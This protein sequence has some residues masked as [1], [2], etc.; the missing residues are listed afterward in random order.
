M[1]SLLTVAP[2]KKQGGIIFLG[3]EFKARSIFERVNRIFLVE[4]KAK[5]SFKCMYIREE[6]VDKGR[7]A[8]ALKEKSRLGV[9]TGQRFT[10]FEFSCR[11][12][13]F[14]FTGI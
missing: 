6:M 11:T 14:G 7:R 5:R 10:F 9:F 3:E 2:E 1:L 8:S 12:G 4:S 13:I